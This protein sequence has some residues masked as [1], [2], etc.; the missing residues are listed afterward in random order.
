MWLTTIIF[1]LLFPLVFSLVTVIENNYLF[2][3]VLLLFGLFAYL[4][5]HLV[6]IYE[7]RRSWLRVRSTHCVSCGYDLTGT[8][9]ARNK[10][11][12]ECGEPILATDVRL[13][14]RNEDEK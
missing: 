13:R 6:N 11:C 1:L 4:V 12:S 3:G 7:L 5:F 10:E 2:I 14:W 9:K 8:I